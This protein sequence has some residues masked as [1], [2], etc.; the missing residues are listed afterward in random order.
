MVR[1][2]SVSTCVQQ[3]GA[4]QWVRATPTSAP[5]YALS[6]ES[7][8]GIRVVRTL[9]CSACFAAAASTRASRPTHA[10]VHACYA[11]VVPVAAISAAR[12]KQ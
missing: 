9:I 6:A 2:L 11:A 8:G 5:P 1:A 12:E 7:N 10:C 3:H 4:F